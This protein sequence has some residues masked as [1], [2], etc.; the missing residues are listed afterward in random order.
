MT[1][2]VIFVTFQESGFHNWPDAP[3]ER[4]YLASRH[5]HIFH[6]RVETTVD[7]DDREI[8][9]HDLIDRAKPAFRNLRLPKKGSTDND[10]GGQSCEILARRLGTSLAD[11]FNRAF[12][13]TVSEDGE[14]GATVSIDPAALGE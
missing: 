1:P 10:F 4:S 8:E 2:S 11:Y 3:T 13:V 7:H 5:R 12:T 6:V 14:C 9:F